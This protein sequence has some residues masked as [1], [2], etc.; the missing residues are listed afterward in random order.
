VIV[1]L[2][3]PGLEYAKTRHNA[4]FMAL[5]RLAARHAPKAIARSRF[6]GL[7][8]DAEVTAGGRTHR[9]VLLKP[10]TYM[11]LSGRAVAEAVRFFKAD[12]QKDLLVVVD[13]VAIPCGQIRIR[14]AGSAGGHNGLADIERSLGTDVY[15]RCRV[16]IDAPGRVAQKDYV[17]GR[18]SDEQWPLI[19]SALASTADAAEL[20]LAEGAEAAMNRFNTRVESSAK[21]P[22][23]P[24]PTP[25]SPGRDGE[26]QPPV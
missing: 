16:G 23:S 24:P 15:T 6:S 21:A 10:M 8:I 13:D 11:N 18:F 2:G 26:S 22:P 12:P 14:P 7:T 17:L 1:G 4:G 3:N 5:D 25:A 20:W 19:D 9:V